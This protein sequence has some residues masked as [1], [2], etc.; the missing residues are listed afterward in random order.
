MA[1]NITLEKG[2]L[3]VTVS[4]EIVTDGYAN[5]IFS[6]V[7]AQ[8]AANQASGPQDTKVVDLLRI[9]RQIVIKGFI[10]GT[11]EKT[12]KEVKDD[13]VSIHKGGSTA[14]GVVTLTYDGNTIYGFLEKLTTVEKSFDEPSDFVSSYAKY[15]D[16][17]KYE[18]S[19]TFIEGVSY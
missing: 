16:V 6:I 15:L 1:N 3:S 13:L 4:T 8:S 18:V 7:P 17:L 9:T 2:E 11:D 5:K 10:V 19:I 12:A 14:G